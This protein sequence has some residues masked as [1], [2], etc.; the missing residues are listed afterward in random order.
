[1]ITKLKNGEEIKNAFDHLF[2][3]LSEQDKLENEAALLMF[4]FLSLVEIRCEKLGWTKKELAKKIG[5]SAS[6]ITQL[7]QG[8]KMVNMITLAKLQRVLGIEF[9]VKVKKTGKKK[10]KDLPEISEGKV[11]IQTM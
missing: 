9:D 5:T 11:Q 3:Q 8:D 2:D 1:M 6:Y 10:V 7:Y 4:R